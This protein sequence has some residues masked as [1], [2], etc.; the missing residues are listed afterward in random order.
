MKKLIGIKFFRYSVLSILYTVYC[1]L[2]TATPTQAQEVS[3]AVSPPV[4][5]ILLAP[6]KQ[7]QQPFTVNLEGEDLTIIPELHL[8]KPIGTSG[9][10]E[11]DPSP[12]SPSSIPLIIHSSLPL[13][14]PT[15]VTSDTLNL[16]LT[17]EAANLDVATDVYLALVIQVVPNTLYS[18][19]DTT[20]SNPAISSLILVTINPTGVMPIGL[21]IQNFELPLVHDTW[22]PFSVKPELKNSVGQMIRP[23][24]KYEIITP[25]GKV[26]FSL[27]LY[28][29]LILG[30]SSR[31]LASN[32]SNLASDLTFTPH[33]SNLGPHKVRLSITTQGGTKLTEV[34]R[35]IWF[36]PIRAFII[37]FL[38]S[39]VLLTVT[40]KRSKFKAV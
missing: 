39:F 33:W 17:L 5:E 32:I 3:L 6:N 18:I 25:T 11:I 34:E 27:P 22:L 29:N 10:S 24:G 37:I 13:G 12:L 16:T 23:E 15:H 28:P 31:L 8:V 40:F 2:Y 9:H 38:I 36:L 4:V 14:Q 21:E 35:L 26:I 1:I 20:Y 7:I 19:P 30:N